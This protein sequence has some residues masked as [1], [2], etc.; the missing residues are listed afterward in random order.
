VNEVLF[1]GHYNKLNSAQKTAVDTLEGPVM[2]IAGPGTG[3][4][5]TLTLRI[6]NIVRQTDTEPENILALT[7]TE[8]G[9]M[10]MRK[11]LA[12]VMGSDAYAV[13][14]NTFHGFSNGVIK[15]YPEHFPRIIGSEMITDS[16]RL[17]IFEEIIESLNLRRLRP[18]GDKFYY[19]NDISRAISDLKREGVDTED[20]KLIVTEWRQRFESITDL[21]YE[22][23]R[24]KGKMRG[25]Y[26]DEEKNIVKNDDLA[27]IYFA[28]EQKLS[29][30]RFYDY[31]DMIMETL[32]ALRGDESLL[33]SLQEKH[34]YIL[35]DE[36]QDSN[37]A[38]NK[39][40]ELLAGFHENPNIFIVGDSKQA[41]FRFQGAS[42]DNFY[43]FKNLY[44]SAKLITL[45][46]N[47]RSTEE[48]LSGAYSLI[49]E[50]EKLKTNIDS[51]GKIKVCE[52]TSELA[53][54]YFL[55]DEIKNRINNGEK[56][57][58][59][60]VLFREN[61]DGVH[62]AT[63]F[64]KYGVPFAIESDNSLLSDKDVSRLIK[65]MKAVAS[66]DNEFALA[67]AMHM[68][69]FEI[70]VFEIYKTLNEARKTRAHIM[71]IVKKNPD[72]KIKA[73]GEKIA[74]WQCIVKN[75][76]LMDAVVAII[77]DSGIVREVM[78]RPD[79]LT[80]IER[81][82]DFYSHVRDFA[83][84][85]KDATFDDFMSH[86]ALMESHNI[87]VAGKKPFATEEK[88]RLM[89]AHRSK[90][91]EFNSV[92]IIRAIDSHWSNKRRAEKLRL[93]YKIYSLSGREIEESEKINDE[94][95][96]FYVAITRARR[97]LTITYSIEGKEGKE[98]L[99]VAFIGEIRQDMIENYDTKKWNKEVTSHIDTL[100]SPAPIVEPA[101]EIKSMVRA[102]L[103]EK[104]LSATDVNN[105]LECPWK[106][107]Y[108]GLFRIPEPPARHLSYGTAIHAALK[109]FFDSIK[110]HGPRKE[111]L[112]LRFKHHLSRESLKETDYEEF[113]K[114][115]E[116]ALAVYFET[117]KDD[118][119]KD[120]LTE[121][122]I[123]G[124]DVAPGIMI[125]GRIDR[126]EHVGFSNNVIVT[127]FK[128]GKAKSEKEIAGEVK[129]S[130]G[131]I[132]RQLVFYKLLLDGYKSGKYKMISA[133][134]DFVEPDE[135]GVCK[136]QSFAVTTEEAEQLKQEVIRI[137]GEIY[138]LAFWDKK[139]GDKDCPYCKLREDI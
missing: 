59:I 4:T 46:E 91:Q 51:G 116:R 18:S 111:Y 112:L 40:L 16:D 69:F 130:S 68:S 49:P 118:W 136:R 26:I 65:I 2:V 70:D 38:Q 1:Q 88:V 63:A 126:M 102:S 76:G 110:E 45:E 27:L 8:T 77:T 71:E 5:K 30:G 135:K 107:F 109:D 11:S 58:E 50:D 86:L 104:G 100:F 12:E 73:F 121:F 53:E 43:Y 52:F 103:Q 54:E 75:E 20:Y 32:K 93:P 41:I 47:Y 125:K 138:S 66:S 90:G 25:K 61:K 87:T 119:E 60:A 3:K 55:A 108:T 31:E 23:G 94:R 15:N 81:I 127:D 133:Q 97:N 132:K 117:R 28:Y 10:S 124:V 85:K 131:N 67:E 48:I 42:L 33:L 79:A 29:A 95:K 74:T 134:I 44:P 84:R 39:I 37:N 19:I 78:K 62:I 6:A 13:Q 120:F 128:T 83:E 101:E 96:L 17:K 34:Q 14:I 123:T 56:P 9:V 36:H 98:Q 139:C 21:Y 24:Y 80:R 105:Y 82:S 99:P 114:K 106:Y 92:Y 22:A 137:A 129:H 64:E 57:R 35:A 115:G 89:T 7:F 122:Y 72:A 113:L